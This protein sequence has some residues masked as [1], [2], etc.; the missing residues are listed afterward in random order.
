MRIRSEYV[1]ALCCCL[2]IACRDARKTAVDDVIEFAQKMPYTIGPS[3]GPRL[4]TPGYEILVQNDMLD[5]YN[6][7][8]QHLD[9]G[10]VSTRSGYYRVL[11]E[12]LLRRLPITTVESKSFRALGGDTLLAT[13]AFR[14]PDRELFIEQLTRVRIAADEKVP[15][16]FAKATFANMLDRARKGLQETDTVF[17]TVVGGPHI[18]QMTLARD[19]RDQVVGDSLRKSALEQVRRFIGGAMITATTLTLS[20]PAGGFGGAKVSAILEGRLVPGPAGWYGGVVSQAGNISVECEG[21]RGAEMSRTNGYHKALGEGD[22]Q[23][24]AFTCVWAR[25]H[26]E[27]WDQVRPNGT[28][29]RL[30]AYI[31]TDTIEGQWFDGPAP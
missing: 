13:V 2:A 15:S 11:P 17:V 9:P 16:T 8:F 7:V 5:R 3:V 1:L 10:E 6:R 29:M 4:D 19:I 14:R 30:I 18:V 23:S 31:G 26:A 28:R 27:Q 22:S 25:R 24:V 20:P 21:F 12:N